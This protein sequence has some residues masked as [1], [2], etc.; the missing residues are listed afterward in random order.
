MGTLIAGLIEAGRIDGPAVGGDDGASEFEVVARLHSGSDL[1]E[2]VGADIVVDVSAPAVSP[3]V[4]E[5]AVRHGI[6]VLVGTSG[7]SAERIAAL[8]KAIND[9][10]ETSVLIIPNFSLGSVLATRFAGMA[11]RFYDSVE[12]IEAHHR[13]KS[14][15]PSGTAIRTAEQIGTARSELGP[16]LA[17]HSD[18]R[19]RGQ[20]VSSV[21][22]HSLR[23]NGVLAKQDVVFGGAG[24]VLTISHETLANSAY[25]A[26]IRLALRATGIRGIVVGL[27]AL[28][29]LGG[30][31]PQQQTQQRNQRDQPRAQQ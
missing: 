21:P 29:D 26:G 6:R 16:V 24:E 25:E 11:A 28:L 22:I 8:R 10:A 2:L 1:S 7:W 5:F 30:G 23:L 17:P 14:D 27:D 4:V 19:A 31:Q 13:G 20:Q 12:I 18:Q 15:S 3:G 9:E